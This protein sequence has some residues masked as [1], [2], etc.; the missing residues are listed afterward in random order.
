MIGSWKKGRDEKELKID[1]SNYA[2]GPYELRMISGQSIIKERFIK[3][4]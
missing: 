1:I 3:A 4:K 2:Q